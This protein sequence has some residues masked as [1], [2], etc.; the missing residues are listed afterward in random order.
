MDETK[1]D[2]M[3]PGT[4]RVADALSRATVAM[5]AALR[6]PT[7]DPKLFQENLIL[8]ETRLRTALANYLRTR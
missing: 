7:A 1:V 2:E 6:G 4:R 5:L 8:A 3:K